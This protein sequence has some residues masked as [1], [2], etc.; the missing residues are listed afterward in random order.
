MTAQRPAE[1]RTETP[2]ERVKRLL[3]EGRNPASI[4]IVEI[5]TR[6]LGG[7]LQYP[8]NGVTEEWIALG[9]I[10]EIADEIDALSAAH[11]EEGTTP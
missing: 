4:L 1:P 8:R 11:D 5:M 9:S 7:F 3:S 10:I 2:T 6:D